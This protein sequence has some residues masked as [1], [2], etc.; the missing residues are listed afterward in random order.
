MWH[1]FDRSHKK[2]LN[3]APFFSGTSAGHPPRL[4]PRLYPGA[5][6]RTQRRPRAVGG[7]S[8]T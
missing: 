8:S 6:L 7:F 1:N 2:K 4:A 5:A 3:Y